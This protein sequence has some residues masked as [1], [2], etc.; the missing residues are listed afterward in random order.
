[1]ELKAVELSMTCISESGLSTYTISFDL[2][3]NK[4][5]IR[6]QFMG[7]DITYIAHIQENNISQ[8]SGIAVFD[9]ANSGEVRG[10]PFNFKYLKDENIFYELNT[11]A[12]CN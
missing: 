10:N 9:S 6:Y 7:Q 8:I 12:K 11:V 3:S 5:K 2:T 1:M 4:G